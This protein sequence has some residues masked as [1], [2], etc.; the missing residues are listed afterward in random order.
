MTETES[1]PATVTPLFVN[2]EFNVGDYVV[3]D[4]SNQVAVQAKQIAML[5]A[6]N[7]QLL[8]QMRANADKIGLVVNEN[9]SL[10]VDESPKPSRATQRSVA[11]PKSS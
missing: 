7:A 10:S 4:L 2:P 8:A 1:E 11:K 3:D 9:G 6:Q 5:R